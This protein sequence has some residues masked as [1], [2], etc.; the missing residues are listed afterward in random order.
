MTAPRRAR[1]EPSRPLFRFDPTVSTGVLLQMCALALIASGAWATY[2]SDKATT[3]LEI[4][5]VKLA[6]GTEKTASRESLAEI[7]S[8]VRDVKSEVREVQRTINQITQ[9]LAVIEER[10]LPP[11]LHPQKGKP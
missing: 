2:Q 9:T 7:K 10:Q 11:H 4:D 5:Q 3:R 6:A 1:A 8:E